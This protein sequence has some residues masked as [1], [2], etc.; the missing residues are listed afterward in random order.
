MTH[1][2]SNANATINNFK[3]KSKGDMSFTCYGN[4][5]GNIDHALDRTLNGAYQDSIDE[6]MKNGTMP[7]M[8]WKHDSW[9]PPVGTW[10][11]M[12]E[13][14]HGLLMEGRM[15]DTNRGVELYNCMKA[16]AVDSFSIGYYIIEEKWNSGGWNDLIKLDIVETSI[17]N[18]ACNFVPIS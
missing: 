7:K 8:F 3:I 10:T 12:E 13:D 16:G 11:K 17:C 18:F 15:L 14:E 6:H 5:K 2:K 9:L 4:V 1:K